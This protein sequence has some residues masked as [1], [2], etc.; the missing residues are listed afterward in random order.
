M[1]VVGCSQTLFH[2]VLPDPVALLHFAIADSSFV[3]FVP[4]DRIKQ[5]FIIADAAIVQR[6]A[7][8]DI[9]RQ[10]LDELR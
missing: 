6:L 9:A 7:A 2:R 8:N 5:E 1:L 3:G 4:T 10:C